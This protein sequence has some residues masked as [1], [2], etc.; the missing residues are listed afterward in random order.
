MA[1]CVVDS[2]RNTVGPLAIISIG[3]P[4][5]SLSIN[6]IT[7]VDLDGG[8][9]DE[10]DDKAANASPPPFPCSRTVRM[11]FMVDMGHP[12]CNRA[13][14]VFWMSNRV[15][16]GSFGVQNNADPPPDMHDKTRLFL[17]C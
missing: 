1:R 6:D 12:V 2:D 7:S 14:F 16:S 5:T 3:S 9:D 13:V 17:F 10:D 15:I 8:D 4:T 11:M